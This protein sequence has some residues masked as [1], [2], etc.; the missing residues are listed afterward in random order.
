VRDPRRLLALGRTDLV[1]AALLWAV[2]LGGEL[3]AEVIF[4]A[5]R[6]TQCTSEQIV[7]A[8][9]DMAVLRSMALLG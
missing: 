5:D 1:E 8:C 7:S 6:G 4:H 2:T 3:P 9:A